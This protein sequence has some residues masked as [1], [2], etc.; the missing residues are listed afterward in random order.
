MKKEKSEP[1]VKF[2][3]VEES[4]EGGFRRRVGSSESQMS[5]AAARARAARCRAQN[6][7]KLGSSLTK[8]FILQEAPDAD[9]QAVLEGV[10]LQR[11][12]PGHF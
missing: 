3:E 2:G 8:S 11:G 6:E 9:E 1:K 10:A 4:G 7:N 12:Q 5:A